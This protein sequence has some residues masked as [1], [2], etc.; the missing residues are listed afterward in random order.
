MIIIF[1]GFVMFTMPSNASR[2][3]GTIVPP[4]TVPDMWVQPVR[5]R[6]SHS[7]EMPDML[8]SVKTLYSCQCASVLACGRKVK[9]SALENVAL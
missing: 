7:H 5:G 6:E 2:M 3:E 4:A 8:G 1:T 9:G